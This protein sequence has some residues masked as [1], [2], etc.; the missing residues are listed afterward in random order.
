M[1][2]LDLATVTEALEAVATAKPADLYIRMVAL[3]CREDTALVVRQS[4]P[5]APPQVAAAEGPSAARLDSRVGVRS[6]WRIVK[7]EPVPGKVLTLADIPLSEGLRTL[8]ELLVY[9]PLRAGERLT[10]ALCILRCRSLEFAPEEMMYWGALAAVA[11]QAERAWLSNQAEE[12][13]QAP[14]GEPVP[15][16]G[17]ARLAVE[18]LTRREREVLYLLGRGLSNRE[19][20]LNLH[21]GEATVKTHVS[22][23]LHKLG[24]SD[25][26]KAAVLALQMELQF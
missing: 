8:G 20:A 16:P 17:A 18:R 6:L 4:A 9:F 25:R 10:G 5:G 19:M 21:L 26:T 13:M 24:L 2:G 1:T 7:A 11:S 15:E 22:R 23:V 12:G 3:A 14:A